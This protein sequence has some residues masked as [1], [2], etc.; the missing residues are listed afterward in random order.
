MKK[1]ILS[2]ILSFVSVAATIAQPTLTASTSN[3]VGGDLFY[4]YVCD[5]AGAVIGASGAGV[6][7]NYAGLTVDT[8]DTIKYLSCAAST[9]SCDSFPGSNITVKQDDG[10]AFGTT[11]TSSFSFL[12]AY[13]M[14]MYIRLTGAN[15]VMKY[16][17]TYHSGF[18]NVYGFNFPAFGS[19]QTT[20]DSVHADA[21]GTLTLPS[22]TYTDVLRLH[23]ISTV[24]D[25]LDFMG[26]TEVTHSMTEK[27]QWFKAGFHHPLLEVETDTAGATAPYI[28]N[29]SYYRRPTTAGIGDATTTASNLEVYPVPATEQLHIRLLATTT[30]T[31]TA[32]LMDM[33]GRLAQHATIDA[34]AGTTAATTLPVSGMAPGIY[35]LRISGNG[36][37]QSRKVV[38]GNL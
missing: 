13:A 27:Y 21:W 9:I 5:T 8:T 32:D 29:V 18:S 23:T 15:V 34:Q 11:S 26:T 1:T 24:V 4:K 7:W 12:G 10:Q 2:T 35:M 14:G 6:T 36:A 33:T 28:T 20:T 3:P 16:P 19:Y 25:S 31:I 38:I 30:G 17:A 37:T 22:G